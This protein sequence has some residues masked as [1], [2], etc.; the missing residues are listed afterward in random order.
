MSSDA[1]KKESFIKSYIF[2]VDH[3]IVGIQYGITSLLFLLFGFG[4]VSVMR[5]QLANPG[6]AVPFVGLLFGEDGILLPEQ[7]NSLGAMHGT[8]MI[9]LGIVPLA[10]GAFGNYVVP[11]QIG[12]VDMAFP[13]LNAASYW[14]YFVGG[15][16]MI[17]SFFMPEGA[18][19]SGWTSYPPLSIFES[20]Q[21]IWLIS[22]I[23]L[24]TSSLLGSMNIIVTIV[25][26]RA[27]GLTWMR[28]PIFVWSQF[29]TSFL[30]VLAFPPLEAAAILQ[31]MDRVAGTSFFL[32][33]GLVYAGEAVDV[34]GSGSPLLW[35]H[36][37]WFLAHP[38]VYVLILPALGIVGDIIANNTRK[39]LWGYKNLVYAMVFLGFC[40]FIVWAHHM[41]LT[42]MGQAMSA[43]FQ[44]TT[45]IISIPSV[46]ILTS[47]FLSLWGGS[48]RFNTP[49]L[50]ALA[51]L[52]MFGIG[53]LTGLPL[54]L[55]ASDIY[56]HDTYYVIGHFHYVVAPGTIFAMFAG[57]YYWFPK[58]TGKKMNETLGKLHF[59]PSL[60]FMNGIFMPMF[61]VGLAGVSR[62]M[63]DGGESYAHASGV[64]E[65]NQF[66]TVS[67]FCLGAAQIPFILNLFLSLFSGE[68]V[69][70]NPWRSTTIEWSAPSPPIGHGNFDSEVIVYR[71]AY[72]YSVPGSEVDFIPQ[73][74]KKGKV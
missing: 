16:I 65:W 48:I 33:S 45:M 70:R 51:F 36:L 41:F 62:R 38:E 14:T 32:P 21:T 58:I 55:A 42:G 46:I 15:V 43:F 64:L 71:S 19:R 37:F 7:Y 74:E 47:Y 56:L 10:V 66:M 40:S 39:P 59:W 17:S 4:L 44:T 8:I 69:G 9:F 27:P 60:I 22:M 2:S 53:G 49:M 63:Y 61:I 13:K 24:I 57:I 12:A 3:K 50:F 52:P 20:G 23:F 35:Q 11:L 1:H 30:L 68:K 25:Q 72:E 31:L 28:L 29:V 26:L 67:A 6:T 73:T 18:A 54:G 34:A 5:W